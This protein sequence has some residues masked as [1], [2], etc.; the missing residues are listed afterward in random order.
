MV[1]V[2][3]NHMAYNGAPSTVT[4]SQFN[5]FNDAKY[6]HP[7]CAIDYSN[8]TSVQQC[9]MGDTVVPLPDLRTEDTAV[10]QGFQAWIS[11]L[12]SEFSIDGLRLDSAMQTNQ[13]FWPGFVSA[14]GV[15]A[16]GEVLDGN[17]T[18]LCAWQNYM[19]GMLNYAAY[20][21]II[22]A[23]SANTATMTELA[24]NIQWLS[25]TCQDTTLLGNFLENHDQARFPSMTTDAGLTKNAIA[26]TVL[27]DGIP[28]IY[29]GQEQGFSGAV[30]PYNR[31]P[32]W[33]SAYTTKASLYTFISALNG[34]RNLAITKD[35]TYASS[36]STVWYSD[37]QTVVTSKGASGSALI[38]LFTNRGA[39][40]SGTITLTAAKT[41]ISAN[42]KYT[43]LLS[44]DVFTAD[45]SGNLA[46]TISNGL[47]RALYL[48]SALSG[49][50][51][52]AYTN[53]GTAATSVAAV[54]V[55]STTSASS[56]IASSTTSKSTT[57]STTS[58]S[59]TSSSIVS[60]STTS[61]KSTSTPAST[62]SSSSSK[63]SSAAATS[64][65]VTCNG[66]T[67]STIYTASNGKTFLIECGIDHASGDLTSTSV[68]SDT[69]GYKQCIEICAANS[70]CVDIAL[71]GVACYL[72][73]SVGAAVYNGVLG[74]KLIT[75]T[76]SS[77]TLA[78]S[79]TS[80]CTVASTVAV[81]FYQN[82]TTQW[83][84]KVAVVGSIAQLGNWAPA[85]AYNL[86]ATTYTSSN[87]IWNGTVN[88]AAGTSFQ[89]KFI[90]I[91][92]TSNAVS[93]EA[94]PNRAY[95]VPSSCA[96][97]AVVN[98]LWQS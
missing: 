61:S 64:S 81:S 7:Y 3:A 46:I 40:V 52:C 59:T 77:S 62:T 94:D 91:N 29:Y 79:T 70:A 92:S 49:S 14:A 73:K 56:S 76:S 28:I 66:M 22:R 38:S 35:S 13:A 95:T 44:C 78:T 98:S 45:A 17:P 23:F 12:V 71:S 55:V 60:S 51:A 65:A 25:G 53:T 20:Y 89:Y 18:T 11:Q 27:N 83:L 87:T 8:A 82:V 24:N 50:D 34:A 4:Y 86:S 37:T 41:G 19:P 47:P 74:A 58:K 31:E 72:K 97:S 63:T 2:V 6:Y 16:I 33:T 21:W 5:P 88:I 93:W 9:W 57:S 48:S 10:Q 67:N 1:D 90:K 84:E 36:K 75:A 30:D 69:A 54:R 43:D 15:Y 80:A 85:S 39:G 32:L 26:F 42:S 68:T 96:T